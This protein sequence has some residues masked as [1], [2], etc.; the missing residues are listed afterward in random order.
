MF[1]EEFKKNKPS[2]IN[3]LKEGL[4]LDENGQEI[5]WMSYSA[6]EF[7]KKYVNKRQKIFEFGSGSSTL[8]FAKNCQ[9]VTSLETNKFWQNI[10][11]KRLEDK[12]LDNSKIYLMED[13]L[14]NQN[15]EIF[16]HKLKKKF[17]IIIIDSIKR[18][19]CSI[20]ILDFLN[21]D[22][23]II[24][25]DSER[26]N[27]QKIFDFYQK[28]NLKKTDFY[29]ISPGRFNIKNTSIFEFSSYKQDSKCLS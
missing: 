13:G 17:D 12:N 7:L 11:K 14:D 19:K 29:G 26:K 2:W 15:Y 27:Y 4:S 24:L 3:S 21:K 1:K 10:I 25:D 28:N 23:I 16:L 8:F 18:Y 5:P 9:E 22:G 20:N 6:I